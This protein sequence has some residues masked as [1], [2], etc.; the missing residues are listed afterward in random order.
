MRRWVRSVFMAMSAWPVL[1]LANPFSALPL[2][3]SG[4]IPASGKILLTLH[5]GDYVLPRF[6][7]DSRYLAFAHVVLQGATELTEIQALDIKTLK[8]NTLLDAQGSREFAIYKSFVTGFIWKDATTLK[9]G[10]SDGDVNGVYLLFDVAARKLVGKKPFSLAD[11]AVDKEEVLTPELTAAFP[12]IPPPALANALANGFKVGQ[13][14]YIVQ[15]NYWKQD[16]H[17]WYLDTE[18]KQL[19]KLVDIP[20]VWIYSLR[21]AFTSG[22]AIILLVA[23]G[24]D[25][26]LVRYTG[27]RL[28]L[29]YRFPVKNYQQTGLRV[30]HTRGDR[31]LFQISTGPDYE[32][33]ENFLFIY[34]KSALKKIRETAPVYDMDVDSEGK[35]LCLSQ[36]NGKQRKLVVREMKEFR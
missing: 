29:L 36:W 27:G 2:T 9:A 20:D 30:M 35:L 17:I 1:V 33:R 18:R 8:V 3:P 4:E 5:D 25:A 22:D 10:I 34:D 15:K 16:N 26:W 12:S 28:E 24:S 31:V 7:P 14:K 6:S 21:G 32:K 13:K 11:E 23:Y 19:S